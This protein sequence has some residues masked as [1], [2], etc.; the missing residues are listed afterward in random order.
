[1]L[2]PPMSFAHHQDI[3]I[4]TMASLAKGA[5]YLSQIIDRKIRG[6]AASI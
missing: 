5:E 2:N 6:S 3:R 1:M 4:G